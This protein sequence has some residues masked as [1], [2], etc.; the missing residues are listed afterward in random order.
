MP[1]GRSAALYT[2][3]SARATGPRAA[4]T[5]FS[6]KDE[7]FLLI[8]GCCADRDKDANEVSGVY[9]ALLL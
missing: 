7:G 6:R 3:A 1:Q 9:D 4:A 8:A 2:T 5:W